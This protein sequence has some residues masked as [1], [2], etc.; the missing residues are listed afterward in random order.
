MKLHGLV[1]VFVV[2]LIQ[3]SYCLGQESASA[4]P[5]IVLDS[6]GFWRIHQVIKPPVAEV[7]NEIKPLL[8]GGPWTEW[9]TA[10]PPADWAQPDFDDHR[11]AREMVRMTAYSPYLAQVCLRGKFTVDEPAKV[12][13]L[14]LSVSFHGGAVAYI[15]GKEVARAHLAAGTD[16][17]EPYPPEVF[18]GKDSGLAPRV[19]IWNARWIQSKDTVREMRRRWLKDIE[20]P[21]KLLRP[22]TNVLA[23][24][25]VRAPLSKAVY[26]YKAT[27]NDTRYRWPTCFLYD[28]RLTAATAD[29]LTSNALRPQGLQVWNQNL[30]ATDFVIDWGDRTERLR[31][32]EIT[33]VRNGAFSGKVMVG[34]SRP[35]K[36]LKVTA[37]ELKGTGGVVPSP[38]VRI[39][40]ALPW[41][42]NYNLR[43]RSSMGYVDDSLEALTDTAPGEIP[44]AKS[45]TD[46]S[47]VDGAVTAVWATVK[48][49]QD[50][51]PGAYSGSIL[52]AAQGEKPV[53]VP[54]ELKVLDWTLPDPQDYKTWIEF[55]E[56]PDTLALEYKTPLWSD[57]HWEL[58]GRSFKLLS[59]S[60]SRVAY[61]PLIAETNQGNSESMVRWIKKGENQF[62]FSVMDKYLDTAEKNLGP[63]KI[64]VFYIWENYMI[65]EEHQ[66][67][68][69]GAGGEEHEMLKHLKSKNAIVGRGPLVTVLDKA[70]G[71]TENIELPRYTDAAS[72]ALWKPLFDQIRG[73]MAKRGQEKIMMLGMINDA[74][75][76]KEDV[77]FFADVAAG[78]PWVVAS[79]DQAPRGTVF[80]LAK[81]GY[82]SI[83]YC[84]TA[85]EKSLLGWKRPDL[86]AYYNRDNDLENSEP[87]TWRS[88]PGFAVTGVWRGVG[89]L[90]A[91]F[92][93]VIPDK[94]GQRSARVYIRYP[95][96]NW[97]NLD[98]YTAF[99]APTPEGPVITAHYEH[100]R[101]GVQECEARIVIERAVSDKELK[102]RLGEDLA[103]RCE[104]AL[105][106]HLRAIHMCRGAGQKILHALSGRSDLESVWF[107]TS[108][109]EE[110]A[111][112]LFALAGEVEKRL[113]AK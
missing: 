53:E 11:W 43:S 97:R 40:Y 82:Q 50:A 91:D 68:S 17:A 38:Q 2:G 4:P 87:A 34:S 58:I 66:G 70:S 1:M 20:I 57:R 95:Q 79:H 28:A 67:R 37:T 14:K 52:I 60:G 9:D 15:N 63:L 102:G 24:A 3:P 48:V 36:G 5:V 65:Q 76:N 26:E 69:S 59:D 7:D 41:G 89:H 104:K 96:S 21:A 39:R 64:V 107:M 75:P 108:G 18:L 19:G 6:L 80:G 30:L 98:I 35:I 100:L 81:P 29:G 73:R 103:A 10:G 71:Q 46:R 86:F 61:V 31:P 56:S 47:L 13:G 22:G 74:W 109:W 105:E 27:A 90:G 42:N 62:D 84:S 112:K 12:R 88:M 49:P 99:L 55:L 77:A 111:E 83:V 23:I 8:N 85:Q 54:L 113:K 94:K 72:K 16:L 45:T 51:R 92:W 106:E 93:K 78:L 33:G 44:L 110:R 25:I 32:I 101:E